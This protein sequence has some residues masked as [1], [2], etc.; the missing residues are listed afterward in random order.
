MT[1]TDSDIRR[2]G[3]LI[4]GNVRENFEKVH[5]SGNL[6]DGIS[7]FKSGNGVSVSIPAVR[8]DIGRFRKERVIV[9]RPAEGSYAEEVNRTGGF[10]GFHVGYV[11]DAIRKGIIQ[12]CSSL[13]IKCKEEYR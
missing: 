1:I 8:Y 2:L 5:L 9:L 13:G 7:V 10:S 3:E 11:E 4:A 6:M 12:W